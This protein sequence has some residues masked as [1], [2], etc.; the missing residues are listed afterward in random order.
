MG[1]ND[2]DAAVSL[3]EGSA[4]KVY[5][6]GETES[7]NIPLLGALPLEWGSYNGGKDAFI[8]GYGSTGTRIFFTYLGGTNDDKG[9]GIGLDTD[10][11]IYVVGE[12]LSGADADPLQ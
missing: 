2:F 8:V 9:A 4:G 10:G 3:M 7:D 11:D 6:T 12:T 1:G 5:V